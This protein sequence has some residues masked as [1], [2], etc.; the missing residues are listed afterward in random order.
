MELVEDY[1]LKK[2][3][4]SDHECIRLETIEMKHIG[5]ANIQSGQS[6]L[7]ISEM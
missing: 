5:K 3:I 7:Q 6:I 2:K 1:T 4:L